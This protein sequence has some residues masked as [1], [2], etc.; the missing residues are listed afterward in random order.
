MPVSLA[1]FASDLDTDTIDLLKTKLFR[2]YVEQ[3]LKNM[4]L[5]E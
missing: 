5:L 1:L 3:H 4:I 2:V